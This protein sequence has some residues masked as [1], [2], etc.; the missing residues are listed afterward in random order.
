[1]DLLKSKIDNVM[2]RIGEMEALLKD[3]N[4]TLEDILYTVA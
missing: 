2:G 1:M 4:S 3:V